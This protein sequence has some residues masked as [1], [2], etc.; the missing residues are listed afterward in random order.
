MMKRNRAMT[1]SNANI[2]IKVIFFFKSTNI[3]LIVIIIIKGNYII[4]PNQN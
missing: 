1:F 4:S 2:F 3:L